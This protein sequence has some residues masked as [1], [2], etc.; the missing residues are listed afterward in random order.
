MEDSDDG[1]HSW[2]FM[3]MF[4]LFGFPAEVRLEAPW[5]RTCFEPS[6]PLVGT[7]KL[8]CHPKQLQNCLRTCQGAGGNNAAVKI[9]ESHALHLHKTPT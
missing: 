2:N 3:D 1:G 5:R 8:C 4:L 7:S 6:W 9:A